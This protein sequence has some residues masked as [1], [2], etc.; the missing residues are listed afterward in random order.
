MGCHWLAG[1][2]NQLLWFIL[3]LQVLKC[4]WMTS[5][6][7]AIPE[8]VCSN[9]W[10]P[11]GVNARDSCPILPTAVLHRVAS[12][13]HQ[14]WSDIPWGG[15][16]G[17]VL[18]GGW[19]DTFTFRLSKGKEHQPSDSCP[20][21]LTLSHPRKLWPFRFWESLPPQGLSWFPSWFPTDYPKAPWCSKSRDTEQN[22]MTIFVAISFKY[23]KHWIAYCSRRWATNG[24]AE[25]I[26]DG[27]AEFGP[28]TSKKI[29]S[30][31]SKL[32]LAQASHLWL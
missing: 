32:H 9:P 10:A 15:Q 1:L 31:Y 24:T 14:R 13:T 29:L 26:A 28:E 11:G 4:H 2:R 5:D 8:L 3:N 6:L 21:C 22:F 27:A 16:A 18:H 19:E 20:S 12:P 23:S 7:S 17:G 25:S 30:A